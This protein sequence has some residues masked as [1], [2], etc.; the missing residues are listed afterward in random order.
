MAPPAQIPTRR[1]GKDGP[2]VACIGF[3]LMGL[4]FGYGAV[5]SEEERFKVLDRAWEIGATNWDT[6]DIYG[7]SEDLVGKWFKMHPE[8]RKD[9]FLATKFGVTGTI[10]NLSANSSP[11]Y[12]RQASRRSFE[13]L[14]V[15]YVDLYYVHRLTE[16]VPVEKTIEAMAELVKEGKVKYLG[17]S[18]CS[19]SSVRRA[20]KVHPIA[21]VQVEY[22]PWDLA[23]EGDEGTNLL[24]TCRE[25]GISVVAYSPFSRGLLTGALKSREDFNDPTDCRLFLP[26]YSEENFPKNLELVAEIEKIAKEKGCTSGQLVL[27]WLLAQGNEIIPIPGTKRIKFL[28]EN[29]A[30]AHVKL[31]AEEE[32]K[33]RNLVDKANIQGDRGAFINSYG[34]TVEL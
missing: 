20:H 31:T 16:S 22:N 5:E 23:I 11:E 13:R 2:E 24:A 6:A 12:C 7:D 19:S 17:M 33:I 1:M 4:S 30:A 14:G 29:T 8:R 9:I 3:G 32:K 25:L 10:E 28:E 18:E 21:A 27:A 34:D 26:R 15:D